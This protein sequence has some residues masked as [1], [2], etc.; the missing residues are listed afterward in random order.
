MLARRHSLSSNVSCFCFIGPR[1]ND[2]I[3]STVI[4]AAHKNKPNNCSRLHH[5][6]DLRILKWKAVCFLFQKKEEIR[7]SQREKFVGIIFF[8]LWIRLAQVHFR[9]FRRNGSRFDVLVFS[10]YVLFEQHGIRERTNHYQNYALI[11]I[12]LVYD[13]TKL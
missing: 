1:L 9:S 5:F 10:F 6:Q 2:T 4:T 3:F 12:R 7:L 8:L 11:S 13:W